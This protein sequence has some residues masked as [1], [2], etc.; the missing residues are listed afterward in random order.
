M[1]DEL[2]D[3]QALMARIVDG[4][5]SGLELLFDRHAGTLLAVCR[6]ILRKHQDAEDVV[7]QVFWDI[8][9]HSG[10]FD[11]SRGP[12]RAYLIMVARSRALDA[13]RRENRES[14]HSAAVRSV[15]WL[16]IASHQLGPDGATSAEEQRQLVR[17]GLAAL[18]PEDRE[19]LEMAYFGGLKQRQI[20]DELQQ[21]LGTIKGRIRQALRKLRSV[22]LYGIHI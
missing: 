21:P 5:I 10:R 1:T 7:A 20:V 17:R 12:L 19:L 3:D 14:P 11:A 22:L 4:D 6:R 13:L 9:D 16:Q 8:W 2:P 15:E 18:Q